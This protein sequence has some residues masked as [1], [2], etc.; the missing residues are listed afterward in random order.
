MDE[1]QPLPGVD[2]LQFSP[3][4]PPLSSS[5]PQSSSFANADVLPLR[6]MPPP[7]PPPEDIV[8]RLGAAAGAVPVGMSVGQLHGR[9]SQEGHYEQRFHQRWMDDKPKPARG[10]LLIGWWA[11]TNRVRVSDYTEDKTCCDCRSRRCSQ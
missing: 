7:P 5:Q 8:R 11:P 10:K 1:C 2:A 6:C 3:P 4:P 9:P